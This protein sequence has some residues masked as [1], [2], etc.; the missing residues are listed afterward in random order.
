MLEVEAGA[1]AMAAPVVVVALAVLVMRWAV[2][3]GLVAQMVLPEAEGVVELGRPVEV[4][5]GA[6]AV[7]VAKVD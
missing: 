4:S 1:A 3:E 5:P 7:V 2:A 6:P